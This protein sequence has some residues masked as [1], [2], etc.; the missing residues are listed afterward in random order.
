MLCKKV[1]RGNVYGPKIYAFVIIIYSYLLI[2]SD[3]RLHLQVR[4]SEWSRKMVYG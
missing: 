1:P 4:L 2:V 3:V